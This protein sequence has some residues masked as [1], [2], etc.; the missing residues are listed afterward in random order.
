MDQYIDNGKILMVK[1]FPVSTH[2]NI[3]SLTRRTH[4]KLFSLASV[5]IESIALFGNDYIATL[6]AESDLSWTERKSSIKQIDRLSIL[7]P[8]LS[9]KEMLS[10]IR[11]AHT[12]SFPVKLVCNDLEFVF[13]GDLLC[14]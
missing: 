12:S 2:D 9:R 7:K 4:Q 11:A 13:K 3:M 14:Q 5:F 6:A 1:R 8:E 10:I